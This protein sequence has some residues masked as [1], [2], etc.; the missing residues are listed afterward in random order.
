[1]LRISYKIVVF[2][3]NKWISISMKLTFWLI[4]SFHHDFDSH[5]C[6]GRRRL[7]VFAVG[8]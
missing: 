3:A 4:E 1:M 2:K 5:A 6:D 8:Y 7:D